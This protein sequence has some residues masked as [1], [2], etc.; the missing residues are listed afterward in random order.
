MDLRSSTFPLFD[1]DPEGLESM[2]PAFG[3]GPFSVMP[4]QH[5]QQNQLKRAVSEQRV[6]FAGLADIA[7][8]PYMN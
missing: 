1:G 6:D 3:C 2:L 4:G 8:Q 5:N 7:G